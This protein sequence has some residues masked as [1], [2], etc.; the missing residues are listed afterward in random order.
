MKNS[1]IKKITS[2][3][4]AMVLSQFAVALMPLL[5]TPYLARVLGKDIYGLYAFGLSFIQIAVIFTDCG[6]SM[7]AV[8][9]ISRTNGD[10][11]E[12]RRIAG[13]VLTCKILICIF[14]V[15]IL[16][17]YPIF[18][19]NYNDEKI[20]F[21]I[22]AIAVIGM[23]LQPIW[24]FQGLERMWKVTA[25]VVASRVSYLVLTL[26]FVN[27]PDDFELAAFFNGITQLLAAVLGLYFVYKIGAWPKWVS[28]KYVF[29]IFKS[30]MEYFYSQLSIAIYGAGAV[31][32][33]GT[34]STPAQVA[35]YSVAEQFYRGAI[36]V[37][38]PVTAALYPTM[39]RYR[40]VLFFKK[41]FKLALLLAI[42]GI[43]VGFLSGGWL[44]RFIFGQQYTN[45]VCVFLIF[46]L[47][48]VAAIPSHLLGYP[49]LGAM[50]NEK[51]ANRSII[52]GGFVQLAGFFFLYTN[53]YLSAVAV[54][55]TVLAT[56]V[57][58]LCWRVKC[59]IP[60]FRPKFAA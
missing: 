54:V 50:G 2:N 12:T 25:Y 59:S 30:T 19:P 1:K 15:L 27:G 10:M 13:A 48:L 33:L 21:V 43:I 18:Q 35:N 49:L 47:A 3:A 5:L 17:V 56:E 11:E 42:I 4:G 45:S 26:I 28:F 46:M 41:I 36:A 55:S 60:Y 40:D 23:T 16:C 31:F 7:S 14:A 44:I 38:M 58:V 24:L 8:Y 9:R 29:E 32:F 53:G 37:Y 57:C 34:F 22:L 51:A 52:F 39:A 6:F 20:F